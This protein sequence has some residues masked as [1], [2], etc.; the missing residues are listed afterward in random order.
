MN[1]LKITP[2]NFD[3]TFYR[4]NL[5]LL[6][7]NEQKNYYKQNLKENEQSEKT[8]KFAIVFEKQERFSEQIVTSAFSLD[9]TKR[10]LLEALIKQVEKLGIIT[11]STYKDKYHRIYLPLET[12]NEGTET[13]WIEPYFLEQTNS[14]GFLIDFKFWVKPEYQE[15]IKGFVDKRILQLSGSLDKKG[16][17][18]K[19]YYQF[20]YEKL[21]TFFH[22]YLPQLKNI[23][24][25]INQFTMSENLV[26]LEAFSLST[27]TYQFLDEKSSNSP[28]FGL[29]KYSPFQ[30]PEKETNFLFLFKETDRSFAIKLWNGLIGKGFTEQF[31][32]IEKMFRI[33]FNNDYIK[34]KKVNELSVEVLNEVADEI[35][36]EKKKG[37]NILPIILTKSR[38]T[39]MDDRLYYT[40]KHTFTKRD[41]PC[42][43]VTKDLIV[44]NNSLKYSL[45]NI[46]LQIFAKSGGKPWRV[47]PAIKECLIIGIGNKNKEIFVTDEKGEKRKK[48]EK[49][50]TY[51][52]LTDSS[53]LFKEIQIL[54]ETD[55]EAE[56]Y[57]NL[58]NKL[59]A[60]IL[61]AATEGDKDIVIHSPFRI[62][63]EKVWDIIFRDLPKELNISIL[64]INDKHKYFGYD[65]SKNA[66]VPYESSFITLSMHE[67]LVWFEGLQYNNSTFS[68]RIGS[69]VYINFWHSNN[70]KLLQDSTY[71]KNLLQ[72][73]INLSGANWRGFKAKQLPVSIFYCQRIA[74]FLKKFDDY[75]FE[76]I[77]LENFKPWFL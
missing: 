77:E 44:N 2:K 49:F 11:F 37:Q 34:G 51:S 41:I 60:I 10:Y 12:W 46:A 68:K 45:S 55:N 73:C 64:I 59:K 18:N 42:Q 24:F 31:S 22:L 63:K 54:S 62:S 69:P 17:S 4:R 16:L 72:D 9:L 30:K 25:G 75:K 6:P 67:Y 74:E 40:I 58:I 1:F 32:G 70:R 7:K 3:V 65:L 48:I 61:Q 15:K 71:R 21:Q 8:N 26:E 53:G 28:F 38:T 23:E 20:K 57:R 66:L 19:A 35:V 29:Q 33:P 36:S 5:N 14:F 13:V 39:E 47:K 56:Y 43:V 52:V 76:H 50:L 27:K